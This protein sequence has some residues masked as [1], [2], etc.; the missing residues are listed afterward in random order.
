MVGVSPDAAWDFT[1][2]MSLRSHVRGLTA[3]GYSEFIS[4]DGAAPSGVWAVYLTDARL[5]YRLLGFDFD[6]KGDT[7]EIA[8]VART[9]AQHSADQLVSMLQECGIEHVV[10]ESGPS[11][12]R[13]VWVGLATPLSVEYVSA[14]A[15][16]ARTVFG[17]VQASGEWVLDIGM[18]SNRKTGLLRPPGAPHAAGGAS[19]V[20]AGDPT[21]L[22]PDAR[23][24]TRQQVD[25]LVQLLQEAKAALPADAGD[26]IDGGGHQR[27][28]T[29]AEAP[30]G[31]LWIP[32]TFRE[33]SG[34]ALAKVHAPITASTDASDVLFSILCSCARAHW[35]FTDVHTRLAGLPGLEHARTRRSK[36][37]PGTRERRPR[38]GS[39]S[40]KQVLAADWRRAIAYLADHSTTSEDHDLPDDPDFARRTAAICQATTGIRQRADA[41]M[42]RWSIRGGAADRLV[43]DALCEIAD[44]V[45]QLTIGADVRTLAEMAG[46]TR[47]RSRNALHRLSRDGWITL[48]AE[49]TGP[50]AAVWTLN[51]NNNNTTPQPAEVPTATPTET[52][53]ERGPHVDREQSTTRVSLGAIGPEEP[54]PPAAEGPP[55]ED[56]P[57]RRR[58][59]LREAAAARELA[60][61][62][63]FTG[64][65]EEGLSTWDGLVYARIPVAPTALEEVLPCSTP[66]E[67]SSAA[68][69]ALHSSGLID[70][71]ASGRVYRVHEAARASY[72]QWVGT[73]GTLDTRK[74]QHR[75]ERELWAWWLD[76]ITWTTTSRTT[77][78]GTGYRSARRRPDQ[79][80]L[81]LGLAR[82]TD[83]APYP[84]RSGGRRDHRAARASLRAT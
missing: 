54:T 75:I 81:D 33:L 20:I 48:A 10:C 64:T 66:S 62:D 24:T 80:S 82:W 1:R 8:A 76:E 46:I 72:A 36:H 77:V 65:G 3:D 16:L 42:R 32:G 39:Q 49:H 38:K 22:L 60:T 83:R 57:S 30:D 17:R 6:A 21:V 23:S 63:C 25:A 52:A 61:H 40:P 78:R 79:H 68:V 44:N 56:G 34:P 43:L 67:V 19:T 18:L 41:N 31:H 13:H 47:E 29:V 2:A 53:P 26:P 14:L 58:R 28:V 59:Q 71:D 15:D 45:V 84:R 9:A 74:E 70:I 11:G 50:H 4:C 73:T 7:A 27:S 12:G 51:N 5:R 55:A 69:Q 35:S 37:H